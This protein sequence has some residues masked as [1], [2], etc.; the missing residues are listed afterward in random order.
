MQREKQE[1]ERQHES[2]HRKDDARELA[3][4]N[5]RLSH[6]EQLNAGLMHEFNNTIGIISGFAELAKLDPQNSANTAQMLDQILTAS[7]HG[8]QLVR[9]TS[10]ALHER[11][12]TA[13]KVNFSV[14]FDEVGGLLRPDTPDH[15]RIDWRWDDAPADFKGDSAHLRFVLINL[16][17]NAIRAIETSGTVTVVASQLDCAAPTA[18]STDTI[19]EPG[20]YLV[21]GVTD[22]GCGITS[23]WQDKVLQ[24]FFTTHEDQGGTGMGLAVVASLAI[25]YDGAVKLDSVAGEGTSVCVYLKSR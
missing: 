10:D 9:D 19:L 3:R 16:I 8:R 18:I 5:A 7:W 23:E 6:V 11:P 21:I 13:R 25:R 17:H 15:V 22:N 2:T 24:P 1:S 20:K 4:L 14:L 12:I